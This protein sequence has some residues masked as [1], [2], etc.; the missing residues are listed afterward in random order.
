[1]AMGKQ[2]KAC[3]QLL[4][5]I[6][7]YGIFVQFILLGAYWWFAL[8]EPGYYAAGLWTGIL[9]AMFLVI[10]MDRSIVY[11]VDLEPR[12]AASYQS[13]RY[14]VRA[15]TVVAVFALLA[16]SGAGSVLMAFVGLWSI[17]CSAY[18]YPVIQKQI[19]QKRTDEGD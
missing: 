5:G 8:K 10:L 19:F 13:G 11:A 2:T 14:L 12:K 15:V 1:M 17:K 18:L 6:V 9:L 7:C 16:W 4:A 3:R